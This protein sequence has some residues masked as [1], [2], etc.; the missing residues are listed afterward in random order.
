MPD[1]NCSRA[2]SCALW[3]MLQLVRRDPPDQVVF[4][5]S[6]HGP[7]GQGELCS[8]GQAE[9]CPTECPASPCGPPTTMKL[10]LRCPSTGRGGMDLL[11]CPAMIDAQAVPTSV[12]EPATVDAQFHAV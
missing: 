4:Q 11:R 2:R 1:Y 3:D 6:A 10:I 5:R 9:A 7:A 12:G 8:L